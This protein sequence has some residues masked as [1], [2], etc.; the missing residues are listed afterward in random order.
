M[1]AWKYH[2]LGAVIEFYI[3]DNIIDVGLIDIWVS[4][5]IRLGRASCYTKHNKKLNL[6]VRHVWTPM[7]MLDLFNPV[8]EIYSIHRSNETIQYG[9]SNA[10]T[11][12]STKL[13]N[14]VNRKEEVWNLKTNLCQCFLLL[15]I[16]KDNK[17]YDVCN[18]YSECISTPGKLEKYAWPRWPGI[19]F[20]LARCGYTL[21]VAI[22]YILF[23]WVQNTII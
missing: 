6:E 4:Y 7:V 2:W 20:K 10:L 16:H 11:N 15:F 14:N 22:T 5:I 19:F 3:P 12:F 17:D 13:S 8:I 21:R 18:C 1:Y 9:R 23:T